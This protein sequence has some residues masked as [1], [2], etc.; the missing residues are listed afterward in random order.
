M[1]DRLSIL[2]ADNEDIGYPTICEYLVNLKHHV[3]Q[4]YEDDAA[5]KLI[6]ASDYD[7]VLVDL[8]MPD[9]N[10]LSLLSRIRKLR[11]EIPVVIIAIHVNTEVV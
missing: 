3:E 7:L 1:D 8:Q 5:L 6:K 9:I 2:L 11:P 10:G 4:V